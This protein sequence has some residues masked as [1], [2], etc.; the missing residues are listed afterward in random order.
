MVKL[1]VQEEIIR[2]LEVS[3]EKLLQK[4]DKMDEEEEVKSVLKKA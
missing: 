3:V 4:I 2:F 1:E